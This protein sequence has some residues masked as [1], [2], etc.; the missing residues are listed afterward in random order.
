MILRIIYTLLVGVFLA[1]FVGVGISAFYNG[2]VY[3]DMPAMLKYC[4]SEIRD[5]SKF[6]DYQKQAESFDRAEKSYMNEEKLYSRNVSIIAVIA[7]SI[8]VIVSLTLFRK[9]L[10]IADGILLG[11]VFTLLYS[12]I[13]G[14]GS[15]DTMF[16]FFVVSIGLL[17]SLILGYIKFIQPTNA[18]VK[19]RQ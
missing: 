11:G 17:I 4:A 19:N 18:P 9:I 2:P 12:V 14:F 7:A 16:A 13:R 10:L 15:E 8:L 1:V 3:P 5:I 6:A